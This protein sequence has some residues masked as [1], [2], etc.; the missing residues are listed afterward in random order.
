M[1]NKY[2]LVLTFETRSNFAPWISNDTEQLMKE[3]D[4]VQLC[5]QSTQVQ[6]NWLNYRVLRNKVTNKLRKRKI[7]QYSGSEQIML[8]KKKNT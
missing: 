8:G 4:H 1:Y 3:S 6:E 5:A 7:W 2:I